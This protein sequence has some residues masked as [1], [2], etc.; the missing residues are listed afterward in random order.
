M[1]AAPYLFHRLRIA[2]DMP[3]MISSATI[4]AAIAP[5][6]ALEVNGIV[7]PNSIL[8]ANRM[9]M[10]AGPPRNTMATVDPAETP[11]VA[12]QPVQT[13]APAGI[14]DLQNGHST[15]WLIATCPNLID[16][17]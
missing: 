15:A 5:S 6:V 7:L 16:P 11:Q 2:L 13:V 10:N 3:N 1:A 14:V 4:I 12:W 8:P 9:A 17:D